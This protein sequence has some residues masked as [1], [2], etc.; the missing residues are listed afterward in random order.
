MDF[1]RFGFKNIKDSKKCLV[2]TAK[3]YDKIKQHLDSTCTKT[4]QCQHLITATESET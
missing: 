1:L 2:I 4:K 3:E